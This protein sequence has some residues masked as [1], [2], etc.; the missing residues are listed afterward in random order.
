MVGT[1]GLV[2]LREISARSA[3][4]AAP[5]P[6]CVARLRRTP[7]FSSLF[8]IA[9]PNL[10]R[11]RSEV[12]DGLSK[13]VGTEGFEPPTSCSQSRRSTR[14]SYVPNISCGRKRHGL[15]VRLSTHERTTPDEGQGEPK[16]ISEVSALSVAES[17]PMPA[18]AVARMR[19]TRCDQVDPG[20]KPSTWVARASIWARSPDSSAREAR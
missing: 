9:Y 4:G 1:E 14:L 2:S 8:S 6:S 16:E 17:S 20:A 10:H 18:S 15:T 11:R 3:L 12:F 7:G 19:V 5:S 13:V